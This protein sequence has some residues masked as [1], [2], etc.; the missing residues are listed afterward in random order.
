[1]IEEITLEITRN[2]E[3]VTISIPNKGEK[4]F[5][6]DELNGFFNDALLVPN[7]QFDFALSFPNLP[8]VKDQTSV[9]FTSFAC[10]N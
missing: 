10:Q 5:T 6:L 8:G 1:M 7:Y 9:T 3:S 4:A 2:Q